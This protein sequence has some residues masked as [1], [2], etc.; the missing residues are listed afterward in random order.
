MMPWPKGRPRSADEKARIGAAMRLTGGRK[1]EIDVEDGIARVPLGDGGF[2]IIDA[3]DVSRVDWRSWHRHSAGYAAAREEYEGRPR[4]IYMHRLL[5]PVP[6]TM[7]V[8]HINGNRLDN[9]RRNLRPATAQLQRVNQIA[10]PGSASK[11]RGVTAA[12]GKA[13]P[14]EARFGRT[15]LG[16]YATEEEAARAVDRY[17]RE[18]FGSFARLNFP[19]EAA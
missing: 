11:Y 6:P 3:E 15:S 16:A 18:Q 2:A 19:E 1:R 5:C 13:H 4:T 14:W 9:R 10:R 8:D 17:L 7:E 12:R